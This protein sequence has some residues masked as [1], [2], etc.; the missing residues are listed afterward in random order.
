MSVEIIPADYGNLSH[1]KIIIALM[2]HYAQDPMGGGEPLSAYTREHLIEALA[3][4]QGAFTLLAYADGKAVGL[5]NSFESFSTFNCRPLINIHDVVV[6]QPFRGK[7]IGRRLF[8][9][10]AEIARERGCCKL[11]L[12]V[13]EG[14]E[15][16][17]HLY[18]N[19]GFEPYRL[20]PEAGAAQ[21]WQMKL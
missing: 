13:L 12:E 20:R 6:L 3:G 8:E 14:N 9:G 16:A 11:T 18:S 10:V 5:I 7:G 19:L 2:D 15:N 17:R 4:I 21:F 1:A